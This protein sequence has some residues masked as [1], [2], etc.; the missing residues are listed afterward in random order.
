MKNNQSKIFI[1]WLCLVLLSAAGCL[2]AGIADY[3]ELELIAPAENTE[4]VETIKEADSEASGPEVQQENLQGNT[5]EDIQ[6]QADEISGSELWKDYGAE[7]SL[8]NDTATAEMTPEDIAARERIGLH[9]ET[10]S[11]ML[12]ELAGNYHFDQLTAA[13]QRLYTELMVIM[14]EYATGIM[15][16]STD[17]AA[18]EKVFQCVLNDQPGIF[19]V[20]GYRYTR[21]SMADITKKISF[22]ATYSYGLQEMQERQQK[23]DAYVESCLAGLP[24][25][26]DEYD[27]V[28]YIYEFLISHTEYDAKAEDNQNICSVFLD[29]RSVCQGYAKATQYLLKQA[30]IPATLVTGK[31]AGGE[32]HAWNMVKIHGDY[33]FVDTTWG[34]ASYRNGAGE[35]SVGAEGSANSWDGSIPPINYDYLCI[36][37]DQLSMTHTIETIV[38]IPECIATKDNYYIREGLFFSSVDENKLQELFAREYAKGSRYITLKCSDPEVFN[39]MLAYLIDDQKIFRYLNSAND[40]VK[41]ADMEKQLSLCFWL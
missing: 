24:A 9:E 20:A 28:K 2:P 27:K 19:Y 32:G 41:Y 21:Y 10:I 4:T 5:Q 8:A 31:V 3:V 16:S 26:G 30:G 18:I 12:A 15:V 14:R 33:Y 23:I 38:P 35:D 1:S 22:T 29:E 39:Q 17:P 37:T 13:E 11:G 40:I 25:A 7:E 36:T 6:G 34:D